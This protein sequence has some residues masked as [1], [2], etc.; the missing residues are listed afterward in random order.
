MTNLYSLKVP[1]LKQYLHEGGVICSLGRKLDLIKIPCEVSFGR[2]LSDIANS[3]MLAYFLDT[4]SALGRERTWCL[5]YNHIFPFS[6]YLHDNPQQ[7]NRTCF[8]THSLITHLLDVYRL[9]RMYRRIR[10]NP[11]HA[12]ESKCVNSGIKHFSA[13]TRKSATVN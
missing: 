6:V 13:V 4:F 1:E 7:H 11:N 3:T 8:K 5:S 10:K 12:I 2:T 9:H